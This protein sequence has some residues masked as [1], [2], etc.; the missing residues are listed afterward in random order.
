MKKTVLKWILRRV[1]KNAEHGAGMPSDRGTF[2]ASV[3]EKLQKQV[4]KRIDSK[5][6]H[7]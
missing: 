3:P 4:T 6:R 1:M 2:E 5:E 7:N